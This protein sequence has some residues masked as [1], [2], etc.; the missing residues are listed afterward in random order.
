VIGFDFGYKER[1]LYEDSLGNPVVMMDYSS[2]YCKGDT[3]TSNISKTQKTAITNY[4]DGDPDANDISRG[5]YERT[6]PGD[7]VYFDHIMVAKYLN[8]TETVPDNKAIKGRSMK[9]YFVK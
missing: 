8:G 4:L 7:T 6:K 9:F 3:V 2:E 1:N 5:I